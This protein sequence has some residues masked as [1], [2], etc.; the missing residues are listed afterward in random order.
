MKKLDAAAA[1]LALTVLIATALG[2]GAAN[3][4]RTVATHQ[5]PSLQANAR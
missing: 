5:L 1:A 4:E 3:A 2:V